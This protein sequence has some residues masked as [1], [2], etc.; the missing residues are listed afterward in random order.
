MPEIKAEFL[1]EKKTLSINIKH[2]TVSFLVISQ[3]NS[4]IDGDCGSLARKLQDLDLGHESTWE[5]G[6]ELNWCEL[7]VGL[8]LVLSISLD[9]ARP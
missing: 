3:K 9:N 7:C 5:K 8:K 1:A 2:I 4:F 6:K